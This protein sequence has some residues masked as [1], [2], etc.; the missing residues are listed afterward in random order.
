[1]SKLIIWSLPMTA[2]RNL[3]SNPFIRTDSTPEDHLCCSYYL[4]PFYGW[5]MG[6]ELGR[7]SQV[8]LLEPDFYFDASRELRDSYWKV[9]RL[10]VSPSAVAMI[11]F[12][13]L[14]ERQD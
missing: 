7:I 5:E 11:H 4:D 9:I 6:H 2:H 8:L 1:M 14:R 12:W 3:L 10:R 13:D